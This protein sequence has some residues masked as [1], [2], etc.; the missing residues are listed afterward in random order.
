MA[1]SKIVSITIV[2]MTVVPALAQRP[3][4]LALHGGGGSP[5]GFQISEG[6]VDLE[7]ALP[8][9]DFVYAQG[10]F[11]VS[12]YSY[13]WIPDPPSK[14]DPTISPNIADASLENLNAIVEEEGPFYGILGYSQGGAFVPV[15]LAN[16]P[17]GTF[18]RAMIFCGYLTET[19]L[20]LLET[21]NN[22]S[23]FG[24]IQSLIWIGERDYVIS[25]SFSEDLIP[26]F[27]SPMVIT[28]QTGGHFV[29]GTSDS[30]FDQVVAFI[31]DDDTPDD[32][33]PEP[34]NENPE[35][36]DPDDEKPDDEDEKPNDKECSDNP[37]FLY[38]NKKDKDCDWVGEKPKRLCKRKFKKKML[39][40]YCPQ[41]CGGCKKPDNDEKPDDEWC[42][43]D[44]S[45]LFRNKDAKDCS[46]VGE[47]PKKRCGK[48]WK[49][50]KLLKYCP[51]TC[52]ACEKW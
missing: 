11:P 39:K 37:D 27:T 18:E 2:V 41:A 20:G 7:S 52:F 8:E 10:G 17:V 36:E 32:E 21:V 30:T 23:P 26:K 48:K 9:F 22:Q 42:I 29:P 6:M 3:K 50:K 46:W 28:S 5:T 25:P 49:K 35:D 43:D 4:I 12:Q 31:R 51:Q 13:L 40:E 34:D 38:Q 15:Y 47:N 33:D 44:E 1:L 16:T 19:H 24:G 14:D 45:F